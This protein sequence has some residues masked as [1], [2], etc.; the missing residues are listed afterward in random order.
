M[1][2]LGLQLLAREGRQSLPQV[3]VLGKVSIVKGD[4]LI[5][6]DR[7][8]RL[9]RLRCRP[10]DRQVFLLQMRLILLH[11]EQHLAQAGV[12][13]TDRHK[14]SVPLILLIP[15]ADQEKSLMDRDLGPVDMIPADEIGEGIV[16]GEVGIDL[17]EG[18]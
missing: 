1:V 4:H 14:V 7:L 11:I 16:T 8:Q 9:Y 15:E 2:A 13:G 5:R 17:A 6:V 18:L 10:H 12:I 3:D